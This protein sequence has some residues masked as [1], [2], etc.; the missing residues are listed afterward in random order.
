MSPARSAAGHKWALFTV[1]ELC[2]QGAAHIL[3]GRWSG[4]SHPDRIEHTYGPERGNQRAAVARCDAAGRET[5]KRVP[6]RALAQLG[7]DGCRAF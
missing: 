4:T 6:K 5:A 2:A 3:C 1:T 7:L